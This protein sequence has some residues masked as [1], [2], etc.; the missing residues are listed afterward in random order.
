MIKQQIITS[1]KKAKVF[2]NLSEDQIDR[3]V[4]ISNEKNFAKGEC[5]FEAG[6]PSDEVIILITGQLEIS[7]NDDY[8]ATIDETGIAGEIG[9]FTNQP[10]SANVIALKKSKAI[11]ISRD[12]LIELAHTD[13][14]MGLQIYQNIITILCEHLRRNN[15]MM[16]F[17]HLLEK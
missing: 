1:L 3:I 10:R 16:G 9:I 8:L 4:S 11:S 5:V 7:V 2:N 14:D 6:S 13:K 15:L 12:N 17:E